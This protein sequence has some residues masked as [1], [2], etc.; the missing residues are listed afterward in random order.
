MADQEFQASKFQQLD[1]E[2]IEANVFLDS[3]KGKGSTELTQNLKKEFSRF[4]RSCLVLEIHDEPGSEKNS[5]CINGEIGTKKEESPSIAKELQPK[6]VERPIK[7][8]GD[9]NNILC[10][11]I[12]LGVRVSTPFINTFP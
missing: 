4:P 6:N 10:M 9:Q 2:V 7:R 3:D 5:S 8:R 12:L 11:V 1:N